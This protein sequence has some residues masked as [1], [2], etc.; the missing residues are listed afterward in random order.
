[1]RLHQKVEQLHSIR[2]SK[3]KLGGD[4]DLEKEVVGGEILL[5]LNYYYLF[6]SNYIFDVGNLRRC[7]FKQAANLEC[8]TE[9]NDVC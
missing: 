7:I 3:Q 8:Q 5:C 2:Q 1:M 9:D 4:E 6:Y